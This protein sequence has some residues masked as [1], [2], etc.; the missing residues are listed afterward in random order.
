M[1]YKYLSNSYVDFLDSILKLLSENPIYLS[2]NEI[3]KDVC[4][5]GDEFKKLLPKNFEF[6]FL[7][8][9]LNYL[10]DNKLIS[11]LTTGD[12]HRFIITYEGI[13]IYRAGGLL[14]KKTNARIKSY[15]Q[16]AVW[17]VTLVTFLF[18]SV[19]LLYRKCNLHNQNSLD[20]CSCK[21]IST[22]SEKTLK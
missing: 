9:A 6:Q 4:F 2:K 12:L 8:I 13:F 15:L 21:N 22:K 19:S 3:Y 16:N 18:T 14:K 11:K 17:V 5:S 1:F 7:E 10:E 20:K